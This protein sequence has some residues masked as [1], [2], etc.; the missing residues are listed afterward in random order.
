MFRQV[1]LPR[2]VPGALLLHSMPGRYEAF[3]E[4]RREMDR[5]KI[6][7]IVCLAPLD[8]IKEKSPDYAIAIA[9]SEL[10]PIHHLFPVADY[11]A[12]DDL[13]A[14]CALV[15]E[16]ATAI[17]EG[18]RVL[19]HCGAG[20]GRTGTFAICVLIALGFTEGD[21]REAV[22]KSGSEP[23]QPSQE[24]AIR[25]VAAKLGRYP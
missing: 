23:E 15:R 9:R 18:E 8:E 19:V 25:S 5:L 6:T 12:P 21:A 24:A 22:G 13:D 14:F 7:R 11:G 10:K 1:N 17:R 16:V 3:E 2:E 20:K 4:A